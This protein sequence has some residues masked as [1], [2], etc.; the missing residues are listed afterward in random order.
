MKWD[1]DTD[2]FTKPTRCPKCL[3]KECIDGCKKPA[4]ISSTPIVKGGVE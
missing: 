3:N 4:N 1:K 2:A